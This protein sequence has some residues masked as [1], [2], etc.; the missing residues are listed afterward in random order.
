M[1]NGQT[2]QSK[3]VTADD[4]W[5]WDFT[6]LAEYSGGEKIKYTVEEAGVENGRITINGAEYTVTVDGYTITNTHTPEKINVTVTKT[7][8]DY[9]N[10]YNTRPQSITVQLYAD[11][12]VSGDPVTI[13]AAE[14]GTWTYTWSELDRYAG[15]KEITYTVDE[16]EVPNIYTRN[17]GTPVRL[18]DGSVTVA[19]TNTYT[20]SESPSRPPKPP[21][22]E[23]EEPIDDP[24]TPLAPGTIDEPEEPIDDPDTPLA[25]YEEETEIDD[26]ATPLTPFT[27]DDR[28]TDVWAFVSLLSLAGIV[29]LGRKR[30]EE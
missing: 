7:W 6:G 12:K 19:I 21:V 8:S 29:L 22:E 10:Q 17:I 11:D 4:G 30:R 13:T 2:V 23:P 20:R 26:E 14:D 18:E 27:G 28:H 16:L 15:G 9:N 24:D 1:A 25:P 5:K 3:T